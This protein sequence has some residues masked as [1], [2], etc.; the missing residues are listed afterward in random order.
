MVIV[1]PCIM[2]SGFCISAYPFKSTR[3][4]KNHSDNGRLLRRG[5][6]LPRGGIGE[7][8]AEKVVEIHAVKK[9]N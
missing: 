6:A 2:Y 9:I 3:R 1:L 8:V 5:L 7:G 4:D